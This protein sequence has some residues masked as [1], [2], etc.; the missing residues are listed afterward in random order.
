MPDNTADRQRL[1]DRFR[2]ARERAGLS[3]GQ[4]AKLM[5]MHRPTVTE[6]EAGRRHLKAHEL[7]RFA[8]LFGVSVSWL[9]GEAPD[10]VAVDD[11]RIKMVARDLQQ[12][13]SKDLERV[14]GFIASVNTRSPCTKR[15]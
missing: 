3:Q 10:R 12:L 13:S 8:D 9:A 11:P 1:A 14:L 7:T 4:V 2:L 15:S 5:D 6:I